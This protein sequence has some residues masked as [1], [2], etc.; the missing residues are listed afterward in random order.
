[1][2]TAFFRV[3][4]ISVGGFMTLAQCVE[5]FGRFSLSFDP[6]GWCRVVRPTVTSVPD[7][8][9]FGNS[10][11]AAIEDTYRKS[12]DKKKGVSMGSNSSGS[13][14]LMDQVRALGGTVESI[15]WHSDAY[16]WRA[17]LQNKFGMASSPEGACI[18]LRAKFG[19]AWAGLVAALNPSD[20][21]VRGDA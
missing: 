12:G 10:I 18:K 7:A 17:E 21:E 5:R 8:I 1:M 6:S 4:A 9:G 15:S 14:S 11:H 2:S 19:G 13:M 16:R 3:L 20:G